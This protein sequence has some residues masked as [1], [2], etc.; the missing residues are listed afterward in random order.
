MAKI[1]V[2]ADGSQGGLKA[3]EWALEEARL[4]RASLH[5]VYAWMLPLLEAL[6]EPWVVGS[7]PIGPSEEEV[8]EHLERAA[9][10]VLDAAVDAARSAGSGVEIVGELVEARAASALIEAAR[11]ADLLVVGSR[12]RGGFAGLLLGSVSAQCVHHA[13][14]PVVV[15]PAGHA[16]A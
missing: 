13:P 14:C 3:L 8:H 4:R 5:V 6:P 11:D 2:G 1:V 12:G 15:V 10:K 7:R 16:D 9:G